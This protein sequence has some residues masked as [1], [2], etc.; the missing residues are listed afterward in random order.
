MESVLDAAINS[1]PRGRRGTCG[2]PR[3]L[4]SRRM[5][6]AGQELDQFFHYPEGRSRTRNLTVFDRAH[7][8][9][10]VADANGKSDRRLGQMRDGK[11]YF[12]PAKA[13]LVGSYVLRERALVAAF[14][15]EGLSQRA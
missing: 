7:V 3:L 11:E 12:Q 2:L 6:S 1:V 13:V 14:E 10:I 4:P 9:R 15:I 5:P 8:T